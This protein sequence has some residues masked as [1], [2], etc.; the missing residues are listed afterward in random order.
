M[1]IFAF[2]YVTVV[3]IL[4]VIYFIGKASEIKNTSLDTSLNGRIEA[5]SSRIEVIFGSIAI[6]ILVFLWIL[7]AYCVL[8]YV[9]N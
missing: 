1:I 4:S 7:L 6:I 5:L 9:F 8:L 2:L 3:V